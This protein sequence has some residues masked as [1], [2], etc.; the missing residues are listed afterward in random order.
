[1]D[2]KPSIMVIAK[3]NSGKSTF[4]NGL[5]DLELL[6]AQSKRETTCFWAISNSPDN[7]YHMILTYNDKMKGT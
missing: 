5:L 1:M 7:D 4:I 6:N 3:T 2:L